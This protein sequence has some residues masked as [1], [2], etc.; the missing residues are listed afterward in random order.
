MRIT[1][2]T[3]VVAWLSWALLLG[4]YAVFEMR[5]LTD[6]SGAGFF[7]LPWTPWVWARRVAIAFSPVV[8]LTILWR[9]RVARARSRESGAR[10]S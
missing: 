8:L 7:I 10:P 1:G 3:V 4:W 6:E 5:R 9:V 2:R